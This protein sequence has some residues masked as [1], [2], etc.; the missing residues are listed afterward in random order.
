MTKRKMDELM[1]S[2]EPMEV[3][4]NEPERFFASAIPLAAALDAFLTEL[5]DPP[6]GYQS[7]FAKLDELL[8]GLRPGVFVLAAPPSAGKT[9]FALQVADQCASNGES[10]LFFSYEQSTRELLSKSLARYFE[11]DNTDFAYKAAEA[12]KKIVT[13]AD[14]WKEAVKGL[15]IIE[16]DQRYTPAMVG[17]IAAQEKELNKNR[18]PLI[19]ID[20]LQIVPSPELGKDAIR[21]RVDLNLSELR[22]IARVLNAPI[23][24]VSSMSRAKYNSVTLSGFKESG[25]IEYG[26]DVAAVLQTCED[27]GIHRE[28]QLNIIK[29]RN[30]KR[31]SIKFEYRPA[32]DCF[33][34]KNEKIADI[35]Y[36]D[37]IKQEQ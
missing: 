10:V 34:E 9:T 4:P 3:E 22:R 37:T 7:G 28:M 36:T 25:G 18:A 30:G 16:A 19:V 2:A 17:T 35:K 32:K 11:I 26:A 8:N 13:G 23:V 27:N 24:A 20:Y 29:N 14:Q 21:E 33:K 12:L 5:K 1:E 6:Q 31:G 15:K